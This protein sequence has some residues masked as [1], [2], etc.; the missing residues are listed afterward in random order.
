MPCAHLVKTA[1]LPSLTP[2]VLL[3]AV[4]LRTSLHLQAASP[5]QDTLF[6]PT[7]P[8][9]MG[10]HDPTS[11]L[12]VDLLVV[13]L[14]VRVPPPLH[15]H[16]VLVC[17]A[18]L[19]VWVMHQPCHTLLLVTQL[20]GIRAV[21]VIRHLH[22]MVIVRHRS[23]QSSVCAGIQAPSRTR[24]VMGFVETHLWSV[25]AL[26]WGF[27]PDL[28]LLAP[29]TYRLCKELLD[30]AV[31]IIYMISVIGSCWM[32]TWIQFSCFLSRLIADLIG[33]ER[34][35]DDL[36]M[37]LLARWIW[38]SKLLSFWVMVMMADSEG[39]RDSSKFLELLGRQASV[40]TPFSGPCTSSWVSEMVLLCTS[41][42]L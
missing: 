25:K 9:D 42:K 10:T 24:D 32:G 35:W 22:L 39:V 40:S 11:L 8:P 4:A 6:G 34:P 26:G 27:W 15:S 1:D 29:G 30:F 36:A 7:Q 5:H 23:G 33:T 19:L 16:T 12:V 21:C 18:R 38:V 2:G 41:P 37:G 17:L 31:G 3:P 14:S 13:D 20:V 28:R